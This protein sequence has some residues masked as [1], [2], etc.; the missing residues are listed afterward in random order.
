MSKSDT[1]IWIRSKIILTFC[2]EKSANEWVGK[3]HNE[4]CKNEYPK[5]I[6]IPRGNSQVGR[7]KSR[8]G[9]S[10]DVESV[11]EDIEQVEHKDVADPAEYPERK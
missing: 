11:V 9:K 6:E 7:V 1:K 3:A 10:S 8:E 5:K 2:L 4:W